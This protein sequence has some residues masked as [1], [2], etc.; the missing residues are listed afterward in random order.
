LKLGV[1]S[2][3]IGRDGSGNETY[4]RGLLQAADHLTEPGDEIVLFGSR[5]EALRGLGLTS[6]SVVGCRPGML[7]E[8]ALGRMMRRSQVDVALAHYNLPIGIGRPVATIVHDVAFLRVPETFTTLQR[9]RLRLS[10]RRSVMRSEATITVSE[11]SKRELLDCYPGLD[12]GRVVVAPNAAGGRFFDRPDCDELQAVKKRYGLP[13][14]FIL[15]VGN[16]QPRKNLARTA[17]AAARC[18]V[19]L[20]VVGR[21]HGKNLKGPVAAGE[22]LGY[23]PDTDL[24]ALYKLC[25][26]FCYVSLYEGFGLPVVE[27]LASGAVVLT[28]QTSAMPEVAGD[29][30]LFADPLSVDSI[31][32]QLARAVGDENLRNRLKVAGPVRAK[33]YSWRD[34]AAAVLD[35]MRQLAR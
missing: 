16:V 30:A 11:F 25:T 18:S 24:V 20:V 31:A 6:A 32:D 13:A 22:W 23:V 14:D 12:S 21:R 19:P 26:V 15:A 28:S 1:D 8:V 4:L 10:V 27:A 7:G 9:A 33:H 29:A 3:P 2:D 17:E 34:S 35:R 5:P